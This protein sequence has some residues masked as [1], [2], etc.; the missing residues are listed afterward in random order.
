LL[1]LSKHLPLNRILPILFTLLLSLNS[2]AQQGRFIST[3]ANEKPLFAV[4]EEK[5]L[6]L[7]SEIEGVLS[8]NILEDHLDIYFFTAASASSYTG[9]V[10]SGDAKMNEE[11]SLAAVSSFYQIRSDEARTLVL[12]YQGITESLEL[13]KYLTRYGANTNMKVITLLINIHL[14]GGQI[15]VLRLNITETQDGYKVLNIET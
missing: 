11:K 5:L 4:H 2:F 1:I 3:V 9:E 10:F 8:G 13:Y 14:K 7:L 12:S 6:K 15:N